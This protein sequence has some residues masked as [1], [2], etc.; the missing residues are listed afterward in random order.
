ML[1]HWFLHHPTPQT[2]PDIAEEAKFFDRF[3][4]RL[5]YAAALEGWKQGV[6]LGINR[7]T[8]AGWIFGYE[9]VAPQGIPVVLPLAARCQGGELEVCGWAGEVQGRTRLLVVLGAIA[10]AWM[11]G[12]H[13]RWGPSDRE[14]RVPLTRDDMLLGMLIPVIPVRVAVDVVHAP[15]IPAFERVVASEAQGQAV[16]QPEGPGNGIVLGEIPIQPGGISFRRLVSVIM[17]L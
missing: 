6:D 5:S 16:L 1:T 7:A 12:E 9:R 3:K 8:R 13:E 17:I 11:L 4:P 14:C 2:G 10:S 15:V